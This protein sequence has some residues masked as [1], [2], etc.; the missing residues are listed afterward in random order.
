MQAPLIAAAAQQKVEYQLTRKTTTSRCLLMLAETTREQ[1]TLVSAP[2]P[3]HTQAIAEQEACWHVV[4]TQPRA[5]ARAV[6]NLERQSFSVFCPWVHK[7][8]R[9][10]RAVRKGLAPL[11]PGYLFILLKISRDHWRSVNGTRGVVRL[12]TQGD[13]PLAIPAGIVE[14]LK[15]RMD[16]EGAL[17]WSSS[18]RV[19]QT[20]RVSE[21][22]FADFVGTLE[23]LDT[24]GRVQVLLDLLG[25]SVPVFLRAGALAPVV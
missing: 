3:V 14:A 6:L 1:C 16:S 13:L 18:L 19:G 11:F 12:I 17:D 4:Q 23:Q 2:S 10:A 24:T 20:V 15:A 7:T 21:G 5:E 8:V 25:R 22:P 9:H